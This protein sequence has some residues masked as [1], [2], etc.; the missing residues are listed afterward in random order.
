MVAGTRG[1]T[2]KS[3]ARGAKGMVKDDDDD[4]LSVVE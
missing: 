3:S 1:R 2:G 4:E